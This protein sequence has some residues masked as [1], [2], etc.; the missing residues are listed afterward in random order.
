L[1]KVKLSL[2]NFSLN[3]IEKRAVDLRQEIFEKIIKDV[4]SQIEKQ[5]IANARCSCG[6]K[7][8]KDGKDR[9]VVVTIGGKVSYSRS[10][11]I[12]K[13]CG[14]NYYPLDDAIGLANGAKH[15]QRAAEAIL[16]MVTDLPYAKTSRYMGK[17]AHIEV[18]P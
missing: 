13:V 14:K 16:D 4:F 8:V 5:T 1:G 11:M 7:L 9:R 10:R 12:C 15:S 6:S 3:H 17:L 2:E 18:S